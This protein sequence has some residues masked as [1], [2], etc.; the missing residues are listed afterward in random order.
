MSRT[1]HRGG[2]AG[3]RGP[4]SHRPLRTPPTRPWGRGTA[5]GPSERE[6]DLARPPPAQPIPR[7]RCLSVAEGGAA[8]ARTHIFFPFASCHAREKRRAE[9]RREEESAATPERAGGVRGSA[10]RGG[11]PRHPRHPAARTLAP[12]RSRLPAGV[13]PKT[14]TTGTFLTGSWVRGD[15]Q[16]SSP[17]S[18]LAM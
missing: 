14:R 18:G 16:I 8:L 5:P 9:R 12:A 15:W 1:G 7:A 11:H 13:A 10:R 17:R 2:A 4:I 6:R 3:V